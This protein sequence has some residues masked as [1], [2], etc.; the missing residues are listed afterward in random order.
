MQNMYN[1][2]MYNGIN[3]T[4]TLACDVHQICSY[5]IFLVDK[6]TIVTTS[7]DFIDIH[8]LLHYFSSPQN[9]KFK[10]LK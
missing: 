4:Q 2:A 3:R 9:R 6:L 1:Y 7:M 10:S 8:R 5:T